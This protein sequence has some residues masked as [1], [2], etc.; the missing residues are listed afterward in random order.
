[1]L[2]AVI[3][4]H[5]VRI[6]AERAA[7]VRDLRRARAARGAADA[8]AGALVE[9]ERLVLADRVARLAK[10][11]RRTPLPVAGTLTPAERAWALGRH[12]L[13]ATA[14]LHRRAFAAGRPVFGERETAEAIVFTGQALR[15]LE[16]LVSAERR[17]DVQAHLT[18]AALSFNAQLRLFASRLPRPAGQ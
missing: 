14:R 9:L 12:Q 4:A 8:F 10:R 1:V 17:L 6:A 5:Q 15:E 13:A 7:T 3:I 16:T 2:L 11:S 18:P